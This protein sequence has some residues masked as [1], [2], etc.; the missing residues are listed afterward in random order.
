MKKSPPPTSHATIRGK[1]APITGTVKK[2]NPATASAS[3]CSAPL[4]TSSMPTA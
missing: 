1:S 4:M 2:M 3:G